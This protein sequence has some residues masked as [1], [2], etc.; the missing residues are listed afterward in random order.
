MK[1]VPKA[2]LKAHPEIT[3]PTGGRGRIGQSKGSN[4]LLRLCDK[5]GGGAVLSKRPQR[6]V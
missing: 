4:L 3:R 1:P 6:P 2:G 5:W